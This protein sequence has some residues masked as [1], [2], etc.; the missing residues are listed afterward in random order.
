MRSIKTIGIY[1]LVFFFIYIGPM[2]AGEE[3]SDNPVD[4]ATSWMVENTRKND[5]VIGTGSVLQLH[6]GEK[7]NT[8]FYYPVPKQATVLDANLTISTHPYDDDGANKYAKDAFF[9][10]A[11]GTKEYL[12]GMPEEDFNGFWG[13]QNQTLNGRGAEP[14]I[15]LTLQNPYNLRFLVPKNA[16]VT[17]ATLNVTGHQRDEEWKHYQFLAG[18]NLGDTLGEKVRDL[19]NG[20]VAFS[21]PTSSSET[22]EVYIMIDERTYYGPSRGLSILSR[23]GDSI[24]TSFQFGRDLSIGVGS[25][26]Y[27]NYKGAV[28]I[29]EVSSL[30]TRSLTIYGNSSSDRFGAEVEACDMDGDGD[31]EIIIGAPGSN[32]GRGRVLIFDQVLNSTSSEYELEFSMA[33]NGSNSISSFGEHIAVG[34]MNNDGIDDLAISSDQ[35]VNIY[36]GGVS[37]DIAPDA[38]LDPVADTG[39]S[40]VSALEFIGDQQGSGYDSLAVGS[41]SPTGGAVSIYFGGSTIDSSRD[42]SISAPT[43]KALFGSSIDAGYDIDENGR[44]EIAVGAPNTGSGSGWTGIYSLSA[45]STLLDSL[46]FGESGDQYGASVAFGPDM[47]GDGYGD[48]ISGS[49]GYQGNGVYS[50]VIFSERYPLEEL[51]VNTPTIRVKEVDAW[52]YGEDHL[53]AGTTVTTDD[54]SG[55]INQ[56]IEASEPR[57]STP[58]DSYVYLDIQLYVDSPT[59]FGSSSIFDLDSYWI[60]YELEKELPHLEDIINDYVENHDP[61]MDGNVRVPFIFG[62]DSPGGLEIVKLNI[63]LD[64]APEIVQRPVDLHV[65]EGSN[66]S[67]F[68]DLRDIFEDDFDPDELLIFHA[69]KV[70]EN[71]TYFDINLTDDV[72]LGVDLTIS[73]TAK[74]WS[75]IIE[76]FVSATDSNGGR[77]TLTGIRIIVDPVNDAPVLNNEPD[78]TVVQDSQWRF[79]S[80]SEDAERDNISYSII[81]GPENM[82]VDPIGTV[83]W[84]PNAW[85]I[86]TVEWSLALSDG[87]DQNLY[88]FTLEVIN[89]NDAPLFAVDPPEDIELLVGE[90][91]EFTFTAY[92]LDPN[93]RIIYSIVEGASNAVINSE[94]GHFTWTPASYE[95]ESKNFIIKVADLEGDAT[96]LEFSI[97]ITY[98]DGP[99]EITSYPETDLKELHQWTYDLEVS[100][101]D[102]DLYVIELFDAPSGMDY[103]DITEN[104]TWTPSI[105]QIGDF[106]V[107]IRITST[108]FEIFQNFTLSVTRSERS[109]SLDISDVEDGQK[110]KGKKARI[111][112]NVNVDPGSVKKVYVKVGD[113][114]WKE[115]TLNNDVWFY[116]IDTT[117]FSDGMVNIRVKGFDGYENSTEK[118]MDIMI[119]NNEGVVSIWVYILITVVILLVLGGIAIG[120]FVTYRK[121]EEKKKEEEKEQKIEEL[122]RSREEM[123][124]FI[125][126]A[127]TIKDDSGEFDEVDEEEIDQERLDRI[128]DIFSPAV[129]RDQTD[130]KAVSDDIPED[131]LKKADVQESILDEGASPSFTENGGADTTAPEAGSDGQDISTEKQNVQ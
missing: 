14:N 104:I 51:P 74:N 96:E 13:L 17:S 22:G 108:R 2:A 37:F 66:N 115:A 25:P 79:V 57:L 130:I 60:E 9:N 38:T 103:D 5:E 106:N 28:S 118:S 42:I 127:G 94:D 33:I 124:E 98:P 121:V 76:V 100:D 102:E 80:D 64:H 52:T 46:N 50:R 35:E 41:A 83:V 112:G 55:R 48:L 61:D 15:D 113:R 27:D 54:L 81:M 87:M 129:S 43:G 45:V 47:R 53:P 32:S 58:Y 120:I 101:P 6:P 31:A 85:Q 68:L 12:H 30:M 4:N 29:V 44:P 90:T 69:E 110:V 97:N 40:G 88:N 23:Y 10:V 117:K 65:D 114:D 73:K 59:N 91:F 131:P 7:T 11:H 19:G 128:D 71:S 49:P 126:T 92:D 86:G 56:V 3:R 78:R 16:T 20:Y 123:D 70:G 122:K 93:D 125:Q 72:Y 109:W 39:I 84:T 67:R 8:S 107:S 63:D 77:T 62:G 95:S 99:P 24:S 26:R 75:G 119:A 21:N 34:D 116:E 89:I 111:G 1:L 36:L 105:V 18:T 82:T